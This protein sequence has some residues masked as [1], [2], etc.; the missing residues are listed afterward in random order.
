LLRVAVAVVGDSAL[1]GLAE[2][3]VEGPLVVEGEEGDLK[4]KDYCLNQ[5]LEDGQVG[6]AGKKGRGTAK[7][8]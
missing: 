6:G 2:S 1:I 7:V 5:L 4:A 3:G 8:A